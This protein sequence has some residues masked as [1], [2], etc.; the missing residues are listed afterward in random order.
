MCKGCQD[1]RC[2]ALARRHERRWTQKSRPESGGNVVRARG[3]RREIAFFNKLLS[4]G[5]SLANS[6]CVR[7]QGGL[8]ARWSLGQMVSGPV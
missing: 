5:A 6:L 8:G 1:A 3:F 7:W 2:G 4:Y